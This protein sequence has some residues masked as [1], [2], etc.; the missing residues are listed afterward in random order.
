MLK[1]EGNTLVWFVFLFC[2][3]WQKSIEH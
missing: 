3:A 2:A 1:E